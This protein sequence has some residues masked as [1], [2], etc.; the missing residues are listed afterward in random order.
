MFINSLLFAVT[1]SSGLLSIKMNVIA[2]DEC[3]TLADDTIDPTLVCVAS[4]DNAG[5]CQ[6]RL[7]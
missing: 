3:S 5:P 2:N 6:V 7:K 4:A 1:K